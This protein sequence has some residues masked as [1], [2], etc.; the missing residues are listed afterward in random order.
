MN[1]LPK[2]FNRKCWTVSELKIDVGP[3]SI[4]NEFGVTG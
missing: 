3:R 2:D 1:V 4:E